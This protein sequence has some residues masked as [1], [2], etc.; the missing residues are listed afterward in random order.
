M[1]TKNKNLGDDGVP[2]EPLRSDRGK[3]PVGEGLGPSGPGKPMADM[4]A[5]LR[6]TMVEAKAV[7]LDDEDDTGPADPDLAIVGKVLAPNTLRI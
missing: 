3:V 6:L 4:M 7:V 1:A 5:R 2:A